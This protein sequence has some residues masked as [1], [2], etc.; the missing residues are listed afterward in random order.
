MDHQSGITDSSINEEENT[1]LTKED[2]LE[3]INDA[4]ISTDLNFNIKSWN[5]AAEKIYGWK[6]NELRDYFLQIVKSLEK[7]G[8]LI[9]IE[10][11]KTDNLFSE[12]FFKEVLGY[13]N[14]L[15]I[16][17]RELTTLLQNHNLKIKKIH[18]IKGILIGVSTKPDF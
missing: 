11:E 6:K 17:K 16:S 5:K 18:R 7:K 8:T 4:V 9:M 2:I 14:V 12:I 10:I 1:F 13:D 3:H 15:G